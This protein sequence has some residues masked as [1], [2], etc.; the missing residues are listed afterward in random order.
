MNPKDDPQ[1]DHLKST[2]NKATK[3]PQQW[4]PTFSLRGAAVAA[5]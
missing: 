1:D 5:A 2:T 3:L 4:R